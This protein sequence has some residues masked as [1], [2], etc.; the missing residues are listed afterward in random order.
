MV[1]HESDRVVVLEPTQD[2]I[3]GGEC[4]AMEDT[5]TRLAERGAR[6]VVDVSRVQHLSARCLG[7]LV[8]A[9]RAASRNGGC[10]VL[11]GATRMQRWLLGKTGLAEVLSVHDD[12]AS[13]LRHVATL[14][15]AVA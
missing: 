9:H 1:V 13:A 5:L 11:C 6:V 2:L 8:L 3:E 7:I 10:L 12:V 4:D 15:R 14:P